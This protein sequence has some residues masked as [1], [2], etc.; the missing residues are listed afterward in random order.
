MICLLFAICTQAQVTDDIYLTKQEVKAQK[1]QV[2]QRVDSVGHAKAMAALEKGYWVIQ[3]ERIYMGYMMTGLNESSNFVFQQGNNGMVQF[4]LNTGYPGLNGMGGMTL[5]GRVN[6]VK[7]RTDKKGNFYYTYNIFGQDIDAQIEV[8]LS[9]DSDYAQAII[10]PTF[11]GGQFT[12]YGRVQPYV[13][14]RD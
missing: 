6:N 5:E 9:H 11:S 2:K 1:K 10:I 8:M 4:A 7:T 3:A 13:R 14:P 12:Y